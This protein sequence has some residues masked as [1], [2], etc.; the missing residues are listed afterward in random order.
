MRTTSAAGG[1]AVV[2]VNA[3]LVAPKPP[4]QAV[5]L[6]VT[7]TLAP[8][9]LVVTGKS[10]RDAFFVTTTE[11]GTWTTLGLALVNCTWAPSVAGPFKVALPVTGPPPPTLL[12]K[13]VSDTSEGPV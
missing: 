4:Q 9:T 10:T 8:T 6:T 5:A 13:K 3:P 11:D 12:G 2:T 1:A 7:E